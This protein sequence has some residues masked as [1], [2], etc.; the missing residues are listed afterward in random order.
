MDTAKMGVNVQT[1]P[2]RSVNVGP[3]VSSA[4]ALLQSGR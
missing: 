4:S 3:A 1:W 2:R